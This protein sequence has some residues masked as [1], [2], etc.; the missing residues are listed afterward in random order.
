MRIKEKIRKRLLDSELDFQASRSSGPGGQNVNKVNSKITLR[1][2][3]S[4]SRILSE[5]EKEIIL[6]KLSNKITNEG[7]IIIQV[8]EKR[9]QYQN[10][11]IAIQKFYDLLNRAF[12]QKKVRKATRPGKA[13]IEKRLKSKKIR[14]EKKKNRR[15]EW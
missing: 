6:N 10:K 12:R 1:F 14:S 2:S 5:E 3:V 11:E 15:G 9:S 4:N 13:A 8:E 7:D